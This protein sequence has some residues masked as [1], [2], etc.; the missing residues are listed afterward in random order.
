MRR[1]LNE[2]AALDSSEAAAMTRLEAAEREAQREG[3]EAEEAE[4]KV[5]LVYGERIEVE[6]QLR[7]QAT[8][9]I[10]DLKAQKVALLAK[11]E[12]FEHDVAALHEEI[13][14]VASEG[15]SSAEAA[16]AARGEVAAL[17]RE[18]AQVLHKI[19]YIRMYIY[20]HT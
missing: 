11:V 13:R 20:I 6:Q 12:G 16:A 4:Q 8:K 2:V 15:G 10:E 17:R 3:K 14:A 9:T 19:P 7:E 18:L 1:H 5:R